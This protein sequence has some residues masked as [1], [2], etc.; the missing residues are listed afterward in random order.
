MTGAESVLILMDYQDGILETYPSTEG[1]ERTKHVL[2][3]ARQSGLPVIFVVVGFR[4]GHPE[5]SPNHPNFSRL[6]GTARLVNPNVV[7]E[8]QPMESE[9]VVVKHRVSAFIDTDLSAI[10]RG[11]Q[12]KH[13]ILAGVTTSGCV[14]S[15]TRIAADLDFRLTILR[16]CSWDGDPEVHEFLMSRILSRQAEI[17]SSDAFI[18]SLDAVTA[19]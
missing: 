1:L 19:T 16:D 8:L 2:A 18:A 5:I 17:I 3:A 4:P 6:K 10:L 15:T 14:L 13:L 12:A 7:A 9:P 11:Y